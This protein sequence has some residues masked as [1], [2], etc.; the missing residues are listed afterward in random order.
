MAALQP[1]PFQVIVVETAP[2]VLT[3]RVT[4]DLEHDTS[5]DLVD[6]VSRQLT[7]PGATGAPRQELRLD[8]AQLTWLDSMGLAALLVIRRRTGAARVTPHLDNRPGFLGRMLDVTNTYDHLTEAAAWPREEEM[9]EA[10]ADR[11]PADRDRWARPC[12]GVCGPGHGGSRPVR[13]SAHRG[14]SMAF[15]VISKRDPLRLLSAT[16]LAIEHE[17]LEEEN[18]H[19]QRALTSHAVIDQAIGAVVVL[20]R[21]A[22]EEAWR[23]LRDVSQRT[24]TKLRILAEHILAF[25]QGGTLPP[26]EQE[27]LGRS[28]DRYRMCC[29]T[30][31]FDGPAL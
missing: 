8:F 17:H 9:S 28:L 14:E 18:R 7:R 27:E 29:G 3:V 21:V 22:P 24:N 31:P 19:L 16:D 23:V 4:G 20:G 13:P 1:G 2:T 11:D 10:D 12:R 5:E 15:F 25:A 26:G 30:R 6:T